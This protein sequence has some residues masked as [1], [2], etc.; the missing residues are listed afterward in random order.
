MLRE[1]L[2][3]FVHTARERGDNDDD[4]CGIGTKDL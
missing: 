1:H 2:A 4:L 3:A